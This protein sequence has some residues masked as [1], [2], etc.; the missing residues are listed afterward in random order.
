MLGL[1]GECPEVIV[2][3]HADIQLRV[4]T[5]GHCLLFGVWECVEVCLGHLVDFVAVDVGGQVVEHEVA[6][7]VW[8]QDAVCDG[9][10]GV[11]VACDERVEH[12]ALRFSQ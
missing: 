8:R 7:R 11:S 1:W 12:L 5:H 9:A 10:L 2:V 3:P 4:V 6:F